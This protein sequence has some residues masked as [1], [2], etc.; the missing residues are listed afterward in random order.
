MISLIVTLTLLLYCKPPFFGDHA[1]APKTIHI[2][3]G[4]ELRSCQ[5]AFLNLRIAKSILSVTTNIYPAQGSGPA[6]ASLPTRRECGCGCGCG[7]VLF[8]GLRAT[9]NSPAG[10]LVI[11]KIC[12]TIIFNL[13]PG[14][15][16]RT[17]FSITKFLDQ[18]SYLHILARLRVCAC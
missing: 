3:I 10:S 13:S 8:L 14:E 1:D 12:R 11:F 7:D 5:F 18:C 16:A 17:Y 6:V 4:K 9:C 2:H 15:R